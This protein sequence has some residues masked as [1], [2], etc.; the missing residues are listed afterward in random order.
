[1][2]KRVLETIKRFDLLEKGIKTVTVALS[3]GAD[4][5]ALLG[6]MIS[7][8]DSLGITVKA[9]HL[10][11]LIRGDEASRD[12]EF[13]KAYCNLHGIELFCERED[14]PEFAKNNGISLELAA[15][16]K[17]YAFLENI[18]E[19]VVATAHT[20]SDNLETMLFN[21]TR[22]SAI[23]GLCGIPPKRD[24]FIRPLIMCT[25]ANIEEYCAT[26]S[27]PFVTDSTNLCDD[28]TRNKIRHNIVPL[29]KE[30]N[31]SLEN[32]AFKT[33]NLLREDAKSLNALSIE[34]FNSHIEENLLSL[35]GFSEL[36]K[37]VAKRV[38]KEFLQFCDFGITP[39]NIHIENV[40]SITQNGGK[41][42]LPKNYSA[43]VKDKSLKVIK[44][45]E[46]EKK[47]SF[48]VTISEEEVNF[49]NSSQNVNNL[50]L[51]NSLDCDNIIGKL[52]VRTR[53][54]DDKIRL[55]GRGCTK[56][57][58]QLYNENRIPVEKRD[59]WPVVADDSGVVWVCGIGVAQRCAV[60]KNTKRIFK[61]EVEER[62]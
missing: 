52:V 16:Q 37:A 4:S 25:R 31:P 60:T 17:R 23:D 9:A 61:I 54:A 18:N 10:N 1:M 49:S 35:D 50:L 3:G 51:N 40:F 48:S 15:R 36:S 39:E 20:A 45:G 22:G 6:V 59:V 8:K 53:S 26:N 42:S 32:T 34:Y 27:I 5:M 33:A 62:S 46:K 19:G 43:V 58:R 47:A 14:V 29:L 38:I 57:L 44:E 41:C 13:V 30:I 21:L 2:E 12:E 55:R 28:Y 7:L 24:I 56:T 11:H